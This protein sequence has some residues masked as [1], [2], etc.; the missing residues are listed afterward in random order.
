M[1]MTFARWLMLALGGMA[2][3]LASLLRDVPEL[4]DR[5]SPRSLAERRAVVAAR[6]VTNVA[7]RTRVLYLIDSTR[8][9]FGPAPSATSRLRMDDAM[10][11][12][13][14]T[15]MTAMVSRVSQHRP[16][17]PVVPVDIAV[18]IDTVSRVRGSDRLSFDGAIIGDYVLPRAPGERCFVL[19]RTK[20]VAGARPGYFFA[21]LNNDDVRSR[22]LGPCAY[23]E[24]FGM[25]GPAIDR[26]LRT[27]GWTFGLM[28]SWTNQ[29]PVFGARSSRPNSLL[30]YFFGMSP[31]RR[32]TAPDGL[33]CASGDRE[34]C[35]QAV[36]QPSPPNPMIDRR[37]RLWGNGVV[38]TQ[39][40]IDYDREERWWV[41]PRALGPRDMTILSEMVR[42]LGE[43]R[44]A[45]FWTSSAE[46]AAAFQS[47]S[48]MDIGEWTHEWAQRVYGPQTR[49]PVVPAAGLIGSLLL[50]LV[51]VGV[52]LL[53]ARRRQVA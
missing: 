4:P 38:S 8:A 23:Y 32:V 2:I 14:R 11:R 7:E 44:F 5:V 3:L 42:T 6:H 25:P 39:R 15:Q 22:V 19:L 45:T 27:Q 13:L 24:Q 26:W 10:S 47:A 21:R 53:S 50:L 35:L 16:A 29:P 49:G 52:A 43:D 34:S 17:A 40:G 1:E 18:V 9:S 31:A 37:G 51:A 20:Y 12:Q 48:G 46:P 33:R 28:S 30:D 36:L 41:L